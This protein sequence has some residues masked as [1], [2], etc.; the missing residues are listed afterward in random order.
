MSVRK[1]GGGRRGDSAICEHVISPN[2]VNSTSKILNLSN[3]DYF[4]AVSVDVL[5]RSQQPCEATVK[6]VR[7][8]FQENN[9]DVSQLLEWPVDHCQQLQSSTD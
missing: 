6:E 2:L 3:I 5:F 8:K 1:K 9:I 4:L 7:Q